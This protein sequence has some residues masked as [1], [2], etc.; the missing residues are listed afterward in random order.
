[1]IPRINIY[2]GP[3][4]G[5]STLAAKFFIH[6][7]QRGHNIELIQEFVKQYV[8]TS[9][10]L[11]P[12][13][14]MYTFGQQFGAELR[15]LEGGVQQIVTDSPLFLQS[16]Y[17]R[18][19]GCPVHAELAKICQEFDKQYPSI[20]FLILRKTLFKGIGRWGDE[21]EAKLRDRLIESELIRHEIPYHL[22]NPL[23][24]K[25]VDVHLK[26]VENH[27]QL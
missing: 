21:D 26:I 11:T 3:G 24:S 19:N 14:Q 7:K 27:E 20:N 25:D 1:M 10:T 16:I 9:Q 4:V 22:I 6:F 17:A 8:Y 18:Y 23:D 2:G 15:A 13:G 12:W 5:K